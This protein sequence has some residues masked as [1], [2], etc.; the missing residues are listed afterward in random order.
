MRIRC[1]HV[2]FKLMKT[3][4]HLRRYRNSLPQIGDKIRDITMENLF[5]TAATPG[6]KSS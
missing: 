1:G 3:I 2:Y 6:R 5:Q 4:V